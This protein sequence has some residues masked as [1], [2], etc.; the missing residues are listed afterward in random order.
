MSI[1]Y[2]DDPSEELFILPNK[3]QILIDYGL[4]DDSFKDPFIF[5]FTRCSS[6]Y[7]RSRLLD[8]NQNVISQ[9]IEENP[10]FISEEDQQQFYE[11]GLLL[12]N[13]FEKYVHFE[14]D[15]VAKIDYWSTPKEKNENCGRFTAKFMKITL[16]DKF[17]KIISEIMER[18]PYYLPTGNLRV[19]DE[20]SYEDDFL[21]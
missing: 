11:K 3:M 13:E 17:N 15:M 16:Y 8:R 9:V 19:V 4:K 12:G 7:R 18:N 2:V 5:G 6:L 21:D 14:N 1:I 10:D 20:R